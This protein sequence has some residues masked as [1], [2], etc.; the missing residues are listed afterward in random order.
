[1]GLVLGCPWGCSWAA[2]GPSCCFDASGVMVSLRMHLLHYLWVVCIVVV[3]IVKKLIGC[4]VVSMLVAGKRAKLPKHDTK[5]GCLSRFKTR[6]G[7]IWKSVMVPKIERPHAQ[8]KVRNRRGGKVRKCRKLVAGKS[9]K[10]PKHGA[11]ISC[12]S[13]FSTRFGT[14]WKKCDGAEN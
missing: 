13:R 4:V 5:I 11:K 14:I 3:P 9:A 12:L 8:K 1:M 2:T 7:T 10:L 6:F